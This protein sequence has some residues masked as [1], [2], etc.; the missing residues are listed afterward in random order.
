MTLRSKVFFYA[1]L[2]VL[3]TADAATA[4]QYRVVDLGQVGAVAINASGQV[5]CRGGDTPLSALVYS[6][7]AFTPIPTLP[8]GW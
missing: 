2:L 7:G 3:L 6:N 1:I 5:L 8:G 4:A